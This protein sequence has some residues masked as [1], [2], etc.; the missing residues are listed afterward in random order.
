MRLLLLGRGRMGRLVESPGGGLRRRGGGSPRPGLE[1]GRRRSD[2][3][4]LPRNRRGDRL[5]DG[6][7]HARQ[8]PAARG[9][10][11]RAGGRNHR[12]AR[13]RGRAARRGGEGGHRRG[14][15]RQLLA[16]RERARGPERERRA[17]AGAQPRATAPSF[18]RRTT[19]RRRTRP[20]ARRSR[21]GGP[22]SAAAIRA[23]STWLRRAPASSPARTR[24]A[25]TRPA[26]T[27]E[28]THT[29][30]DRATFA[31]GALAAARWRARAPGLVHDAGRAGTHG[32]GLGGEEMRTPFTGCGTALVT[33]FTTAGAVDE[34]AVRRLAQAAD[35]RGH[36]L[37]GAVRHDRRE[38]RRSRADE[39]RRV[40]ELVVAE[41]AG[42]VPVLAGAGGYDTRE[43]IEAAQEMQAAGA[44]RPAVGDALLQQA[45]AR[46][47][48]P[49]L[50]GDRR[51][52]AAADRRLQRARPHR[53]QRGP[54]RRCARLA[55]IPNVVGVKEASGNMT[56]MCEVLQRRA[57]GASSCSR[58]T[59]RS[60]CR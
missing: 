32:H 9:P 47:P 19:R 13:A 28:L 50:P 53:L 37:P 1:S 22:W 16:R 56:Q 18:T 38:R 33:P 14:R 20:R 57:A 35:R 3:R 8:R 44:E 58:A 59:T 55:T 41:A 11:H 31:H 34:A 24:S 39:R 26:E 4:A 6:R 2:R 36:A 10:G 52:D 42:R 15:R 25:S 48:L 21:C 5:L 17:A 43:V 60:R 12:L 49:A 40:V 29:V 7:G 54:A 51:G 45:D 46:G 30:R 27:L 23:E